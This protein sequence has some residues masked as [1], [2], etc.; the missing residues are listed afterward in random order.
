MSAATFDLADTF[1]IARE[2]E[3][4][5]GDS[6]VQMLKDKAA[7]GRLTIAELHECI[8]KALASVKDS[9]KCLDDTDYDMLRRSNASFNEGRFR[10][11]QEILS[12]IHRRSA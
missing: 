8:E 12:D 3:K 4:H 10:T 1:E 9:T 2:L 5:V 11:A 6:L 7:D